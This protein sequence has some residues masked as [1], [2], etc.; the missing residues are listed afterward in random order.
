MILNIYTQDSIS[1]GR[2]KGNRVLDANTY[3]QRSKRTINSR[4]DDCDALADIVLTERVWLLVLSVATERL[5]MRSTTRALL[6]P[7]A[8]LTTE[9]TPLLAAE[10]TALIVAEHTALLGTERTELLPARRATL[11]TIKCAESLATDCTALLATDPIS[12]LAT[13]SATLMLTGK[14]NARL[15]LSATLC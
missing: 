6:L 5:C 7:T 4:S 1:T 8:L 13:E 14:C 12:L 10:H 9:Y 15:A 11:I 2:K 3:Q